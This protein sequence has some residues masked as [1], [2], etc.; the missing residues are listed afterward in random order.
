MDD[1]GA[2]AT[3]P[4][5]VHPV[6][7]RISL[8]FGV[9]PARALV[10]VHTDR[11]V[12]RFGPWVVETPLGNVASAEVSGPYGALRVVGPARLSLADRGL[13]FATTDRAGA[14]LRFHEPVPGLDPLGLVRHPGLTVTVA[15][16]WALVELLGHLGAH[17]P[18]ATSGPARPS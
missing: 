15:E 13:T 12:A 11:V 18:D 9:S 4:F 10:A 8:I 2:L 17:L 1:D 6:L 5:A 14:C 16:P 3:F 7:G